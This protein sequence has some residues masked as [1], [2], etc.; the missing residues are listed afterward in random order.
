[1]EPEL[2]KAG[3]EIISKVVVIDKDEPT[4]QRAGS[5]LAKVV[6]TVAETI[7]TCLLP[8]TALNCA[9]KRAKK[10]FDDLF[11][12]DIESVTKNIPAD[13]VI[14]PKASVA[15]PAIQGLALTHDEASLKEMFLALLGSA[16]N[17]DTAESVHPGFADIIR[18]LDA[19]EASLLASVLRVAVPLSVVQLRLPAGLADYVVVKN[20]ILNV[21]DDLGQPATYPKLGIWVDNWQRLGLVTVSYADTKWW[22]RDTY[23]AQ[24]LPSVQEAMESTN[25]ALTP[26]HLAPGKLHLTELGKAFAK[27]VGVHPEEVADPA[28]EPE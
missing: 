9:S 19:E 10:Y 20:H 18:Q 24:D 13:K 27:A 5:E 26:S 21:V 14:E 15:A 12:K 3:A 8:F 23:W 2:F 6:V 22:N 25:H 16:M 4:A 17:S 1:M 11:E 28:V 7:Q